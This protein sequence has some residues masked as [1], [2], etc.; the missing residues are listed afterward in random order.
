M[1]P[2][3]GSTKSL[4]GPCHFRLSISMLKSYVHWSPSR[5]S[6]PLKRKNEGEM[7]DFPKILRIVCVSKVV[8]GKER[9][10]SDL[11]TGK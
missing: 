6:F 9:G 3:Y 7:Q 8:T 2:F 1:W 10:V 11:V 5:A 4:K